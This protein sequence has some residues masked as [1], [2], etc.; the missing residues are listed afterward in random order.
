VGG[1]LAVVL[2]LGKEMIG[3]FSRDTREQ[4]DLHR[5]SSANP[6]GLLPRPS[7]WARGQSGRPLFLAMSLYVVQPPFRTD[8]NAAIRV[9]WDRP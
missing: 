7:S 4:R 5:A 6:G 2:L 1:T 9:E 3:R 8:P